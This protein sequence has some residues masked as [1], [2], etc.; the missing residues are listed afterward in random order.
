MD[1]FGVAISVVKNAT[2]QQ[3]EIQISMFLP[4]RKLRIV[5]Y[6]QVRRGVYERVVSFF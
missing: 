4:A 6:R 3:R 5:L 2:S 1:D